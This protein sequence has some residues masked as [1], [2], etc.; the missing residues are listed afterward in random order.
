MNPDLGPAERWFRTLGWTAFPFQRETWIRY[1]AGES[2]LVHAPTGTGK[3]YA[4]WIGPLL[5]SKDGPPSDGARVVWLTPLRALAADLRG[6][7]ECAARGLGIDWT[8]ETRTGDTGAAQRAR[9]AERLPDALVTTPESLTVL[10]SRPDA[11]LRFAGLRCVVCD[12]W[13]ELLGTK[14]GVQTELALARLRCFAPEL[15]TWGLSA[16]I[17]N[18]DE[19]LEVLLGPTD[20]TGTIVRDATPKT[21]EV[22]TLRPADVGRFPWSGHIGLRLLEDVVLRLETCRSALVFTNTRNQAEAWYRALLE[23]RPEWDGDVALHHGSLDRTHREEVEDRLRDGSLRCVVATSSLDL[24]VDFSPVE[25]VF[26][27]GSPKGIGRLVQRAGRSGHRPGEA[28]RVYGV[29]A[30][31]FELVEFAAARDAVAASA[32]EAREPLRRPL[33]VLAQHLVTVAAGGGFHEDALYHEVR[34]TW[35]YRDL[36]RD[37]WGWT[38]DFAARGGAALAAY[39]E[40][41]RIERDADGLWRVRDDRLA[42]RHRMNIGTIASDPA[43]E[44]RFGNGRLLGTVEERFAAGL[45]PG[46]RFVFAGR[47]LE[48]VGLRDVVLRVRAARR[49]RGIVPQWGGGRFPLSSHLAHG[50]LARLEQASRG[51]HEGPEMQAVRPLLELQRRCSAL[52]GPGTIL[53]ESLRTEEGHH[54]FLFPFLGRAAH[55]GLAAVVAHRLAAR[56]PAT[57]T[58]VV[59][60]YGVELRSTAPIGLD[61]TGWRGV[62]SEDGL[63]DD[64][65]ACLNEGELSRRRFREIARVA[66][67]VFPGFP[68]RKKS[69]RQLQTSSGLLF[70][71]FTRYDPGNLLLHQAR[72]EVLEG[73]LEVGRLARALRELGDRRMILVEPP[74]L[75]PLAFPL[76]A[77]SLQAVEVSTEDWR[78]RVERMSE[79]LERRA[80]GARG[81]RRT[82]R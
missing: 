75:T 5:E 40:Y 67:L 62:L 43:I 44:V 7:L 25:R 80:R 39:P 81:G 26:Q 14:R 73:Q 34:S 54:A 11:A 28:S 10:L 48:V 72:R 82:R 36:D 63:L 19:A 1:L 3:S 79:A 57:V 61:E 41:R 46:S 77:E 49:G 17:G 24:G 27:V 59:N 15:R 55:E 65:L 76:W 38:L 23:A 12:E 31:A 78:T 60:D 22:E 50:V 69:A 66:G 37:A 71:V 47:T 16:S 21:I 18:L 2:G 74:H 20:A 42:R 32:I 52:P 56:G 8:V 13:H 35:A 45:R 53:I 30:H 64:L 6:N 29:P 70:D 4:G 9:Q 68:G 33:D 58:S 51:R